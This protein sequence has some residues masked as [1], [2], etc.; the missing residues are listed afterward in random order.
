M[1][2][3]IERAKLKEVL[4]TVGKA[5]SSRTTLDILKGIYVE[6]KKDCVKFVGNDL[7]LGIEGFIQEGINVTEEG[8]FVTNFKLLDDIISKRTED[9]VSFEAKDSKNI[10]VKSGKAEYKLKIED[11]EQYPKVSEIEEGTTFEVNGDILSDMINKVKVSIGTDETRPV[12][13]GGLIEIRNNKLRVVALNGYHLSY[14]YEQIDFE[15]ELKAII[16]AKSL[17]EVARAVIG[18]DNVKISFTSQHCLVETGEYRFVTILIDG[19]FMDYEGIFPTQ[20]KTKFTVDR[21]DFKKILECISLVAK[22]GKNNSVRMILK[23]DKVLFRA[24]SEI[25]SAKEEIKTTV[26]GDNFIVCFNSTYLI[27]GVKNLSSEKITMEFTTGV[28]PAIIKPSDENFKYLVLPVRIME[29]QYPDD[30]KE[31]NEK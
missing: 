22:E 8:A 18:I 9:I 26:E 3:T 24:D 15:G 1:K 14:A 11:G 31:L 23:S 19:N 16:P 25:A 5:V 4:K 12:L 28:N 29:G 30:E 10:K 7:E 17:I 21:N 27:D 20:Y 13:T 6:V 2:F